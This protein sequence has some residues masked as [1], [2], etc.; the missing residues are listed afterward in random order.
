[1]YETTEE[2]FKEFAKWT[3]HYMHLFRLMDWRII[4]VWEDLE[5]EEYDARGMAQEDKAERDE[6]GD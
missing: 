6:F 2:E 1:M 4:P 5:N 3:K